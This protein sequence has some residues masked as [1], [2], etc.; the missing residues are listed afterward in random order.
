MLIPAPAMK[1]RL[2]AAGFDRIETRYRVFF[3]NLLKRLRPLES[4]LAPVPLGG[5]Y[6]LSA[7]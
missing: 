5:Q 3:P 2:R 6:V 7:G 1:R 4:L